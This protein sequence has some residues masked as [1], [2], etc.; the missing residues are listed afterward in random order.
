MAGAGTDKTRSWIETPGP[1]I[2]LVEPQLGE[3]IGAAARVMA[4]FG[5]ARLRLVEPRD[6]WP[7]IHARRAAAGA[8][9]ILDATALYD[10]VAAAIADCTAV[11]ATTARAHDQAKPVLGPQ[12]AAAL[13]AP[14]V[15]AGENVAVLFGR[16]RHG[17]EN[18]EVALADGIVTFPVNPAFASLNLAQA[19]ALVAYEWFKLASGGA[20]PF[21]MPRKSQP[22]PKQ[23]IEAFFANLERQLDLI[24][25]FRPLDKRATMLVNLRN[26]FA[27]MQPTQ[28]DIQTL[29][30]IVVALT[31]GR[32]G[33]ARGGVLDGEEATALRALLAEYGDARA[34][35]ER[36]PV[37]GLARLLRRN[38]TD[39]ERALWDG[40]TQ[41][42]RFAGQGFK[43][44]VPVG[45]HIT[46]FVSFPL[47]VVIDVVPPQESAAAA[48]ARNDRRAWLSERGYRVLAVEANAVERDLPQ[49]LDRLAQ[50]MTE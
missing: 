45:T 30:G 6:G 9:R 13:L 46:D 37:R 18:H 3:N 5:L 47:R 31:E 26:I 48:K 8:D 7:N 21:A 34:P 12:E 11:L 10:S 16:E 2:V 39:A 24:E 14:R 49:V 25:Y 42:R 17:L 40:L 35:G 23:Q 22:A 29:H 36:G 4:N 20:L 43:R 41:D 1:I 15:A 50:E 32:K 33:P 38:P 27:R 19:V 44:Q 28:Q